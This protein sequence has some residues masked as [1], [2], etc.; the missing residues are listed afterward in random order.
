MRTSIERNDAYMPK[1]I[2]VTRES[3]SGRNE[4]FHDNF[5]GADMTRSQFVKEIRQGN[6]ENYHI[7]N[8]NGVA[9]P[10]S[11]P[12]PKRNNNLG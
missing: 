4:T 3:E 8:I 11:N 6:Y 12:D 2:K 10:V 5:T 1:R 9:T 7:R